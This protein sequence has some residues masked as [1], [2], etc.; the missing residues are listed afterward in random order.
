MKLL[1]TSPHDQPPGTLA[2]LILRSYAD[3]ISSDPVH[4]KPE[5]VKWGEFDRNVFDNP[6]TVG[7]CVFLS[8]YERQL[9]GFGSFDPRQ[10][11]A[12]G[13]IGH[14]CIL[15]GFRGRGFGKE[16]ILEIVTRFKSLGIQTA[17]VTTNDNL[18]FVPAQRMYESCGFHEI[19]RKP[20]EGDP[21]QN[22]IHYQKG[23]E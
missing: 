20:W 22:V 17:K 14:N 8:W 13:I 6:S 5:E 2:S 7:A 12:F 15:P 1:F 18:F 11:P 3:L 16:Q 4:W 23:I 9:V 19:A 21:T 10:K